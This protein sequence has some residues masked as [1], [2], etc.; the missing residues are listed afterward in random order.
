MIFR[1][2]IVFFISTFAMAQEEMVYSVFFDTNKAL[3]SEKHQNELLAFVKSAD[4]SRIES[5]DIFGYCDDVGKEDYNKKLSTDRA[6]TVLELLTNKGVKSRMIVTIEGKGRILIEDDIKDDLTALRSKNRRVDVV[7]NLLPPPKIVLPGVFQTFNADHVVGDRIMLSDMLFER[8]SSALTV[9]CK[10]ELDKMARLL[11]KNKNIHFEIQGHVC[12]TPPHHTEAIDKAT[13][14]RKLSHN[15]AE[16][17]YKY[18]LLKKIPK[19]RMTFKGYG[20]TMPMG[21]SPD[22]DRRVELVVTKI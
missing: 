16:N 22:L 19:E 11:L 2:W 21:G 1:L 12:C 20:N 18:L 5:I 17:V 14:K 15:R 7:I 6:Q 9:K 8:G 13:K 10:N 3:I 4:S